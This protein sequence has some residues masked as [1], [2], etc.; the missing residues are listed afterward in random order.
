MM[1][2]P[3]LKIALACV[4]ITGMGWTPLCALA[5]SAPA[6]APGSAPA[7]APVVAPAVAPALAV[8]GPPGCERCG[9]VESIR[10]VQ[11][12]DTWTPLGSVPTAS[13]LGPTGVAV[14][15][16][17]PGFSNQGQ[18]LVGAAGGGVYQTRAKQRNAMRWEVVIKMDDGSGRSVT[19]NYEPL[20]VVGDRVR[21]F[22]SQIELVQ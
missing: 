17:G 22:G 3:T 19:Q 20:F 12:K 15:Q 7:R 4:V 2:A 21:V 14:Y 11:L 5:Q 10:E 8:P 13:D 6:G 1:H 16:I 9:K 18:V